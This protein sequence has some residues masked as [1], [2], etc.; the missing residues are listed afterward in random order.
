[1]KVMSSILSDFDSI[2]S[3]RNDFL[4]IVI[5]DLSSSSS[6]SIKYILLDAI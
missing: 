3:I 2:F 6:K 4:E 1:M 5:K